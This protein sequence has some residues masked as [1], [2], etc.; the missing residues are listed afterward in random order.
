MG[1]ICRH[2]MLSSVYCGW[3]RP[4]GAHKLRTT[5]TA[6]EMDAGTDCT[7]LSHLVDPCT[8]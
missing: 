6:G 8:K 5:T 1:A 3:L 7:L 4:R 2:L